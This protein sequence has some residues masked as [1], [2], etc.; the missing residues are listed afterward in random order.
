MV[1]ERVKDLIRSKAKIDRE[2]IRVVLPTSEEPRCII[3]ITACTEAEYR[4]IQRGL[5]ATAPEGMMFQVMRDE[6]PNKP[7]AY[8][9]E[10]L[11]EMLKGF[12]TAPDG[13]LAES[14]A[15]Q[16][17]RFAES[18][19]HT[20]PETLT[21]LRNLRD[22]LVFCSGAS[23]FVLQVI[24]MMLEDYPEPEDEMDERRSHLP[25]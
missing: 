8:N 23:S 5:N 15:K 24:N 1:E 3:G 4:G 25:R 9:L 12:G 7:P 10:R 17:A 18:E 22:N 14:F 20:L 13:H 11:R 6:D 2:R 16:C 19:E 21:F